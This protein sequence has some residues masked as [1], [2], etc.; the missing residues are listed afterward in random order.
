MTAFFFFG[1]YKKLLP[2]LDVGD[3]LFHS[4]CIDVGRFAD[5]DGAFSRGKRV[6]SSAQLEKY[7]RSPRKVLIRFFGRDLCIGA[8]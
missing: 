4:G 7:V 6:L 5:H 3:P 8:S 1:S 2:C